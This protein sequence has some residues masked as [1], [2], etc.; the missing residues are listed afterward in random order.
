MID[1]LIGSMMIGTMDQFHCAMG[2]SVI[3]PIDHQS[4]IIVHQ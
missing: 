4:S 2:R 1:D 3:G